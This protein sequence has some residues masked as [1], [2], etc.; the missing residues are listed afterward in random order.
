MKDN[1]VA[2]LLG[3]IVLVFLAYYVGTR[4]NNPPPVISDNQSDVVAPVTQ[5]DSSVGA[6]AQ[7][8]NKATQTNLEMKMKC[9]SYR[10]SIEDKN[11]QT[12]KQ[13]SASEIPVLYQLFYSPSLS[14]CL[15]ASYILY[16]SSYSPGG[17]FE[18]LVVSDILTGNTIWSQT[19]QPSL[20]Y[21][22]AEAKLDSQI[23][24]FK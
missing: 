17:D 9:A 2:Y 7:P 11:A 23:A 21:W 10:Q 16:S 20:K 18:T 24:V 12:S 8:T 3:L 22:D 13:T 19:F 15:S 6:S 4:S 5:T 1:P 14:T